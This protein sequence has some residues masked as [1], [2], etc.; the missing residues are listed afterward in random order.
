MKKTRVYV[1]AAVLAAGCVR[2]ETT[3]TFY[4]DPDGAV[5]WMVLEKDIRSDAS[6]LAERAR[7]EEEFMKARRSEEHDIAKS[8]V[9][10]GA[11][12]VETRIV[13][14]KR[15]YMV[16]SE[17]RFESVD[18][19]IQ[20]FFDHVEAPIRAE[21]CHDGGRVRL[22]ISCD[23]DELEEAEHCESGGEQD[24]VF[25]ALIG[26]VSA[27]SLILTDGKFVSARGFDLQEEG[28]VAVLQEQTREDIEAIEETDDD[29]RTVVY[30]LT[31]TA[32][33]D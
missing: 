32:P 8:L 4:L 26:D 28:T 33:R 10:L 9:M 1:V 18:G 14:D 6:D 17:A 16:T 20:S 27:Y 29:G 11:D 23:L 12:W 24:D 31:W 2:K 22:T 15:P 5:T 19:M 7:E 30:S 25:M 13:R 3:H 21:L